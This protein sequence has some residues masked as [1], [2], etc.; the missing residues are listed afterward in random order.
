M[1]IK[2]IVKSLAALA[3]ET[4]LKIFRLL[5]EAGAEGLTVGKIGEVLSIAPA[6]LSF[7]LKELSHA[8]LVITR[9]EGRFIYCIADFT[10]MISIVTYLTENCCGNKTNC[11]P[12]CEPVIRKPPEKKLLR[13]KS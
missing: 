7:H 3:Q 13:R 2:D 12:V 6:T 4:R 1:E 11:A 10:N 9:N 5:V 8:N